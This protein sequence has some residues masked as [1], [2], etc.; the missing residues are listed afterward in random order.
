[1]AQISVIIPVYNIAACLEQCLD[2][3]VGQTFT[4]IEI[5]CVDDGSTDES[6]EILACYADRDDR[7]QILTQKNRGP[8]AARNAGLARATGDYLI[9]L[10]S[11]DWF[12]SE[13]LMQM[14]QRIQ[15]TKADLVI[16]KVVEFDT[17]NGSDRPSSWMLKEK[18]LPK[19]CFRPEEAAEHLFQFTYGWPW[20]KLYRMDFIREKHLSFPELPNSEDVVFVF[21]SLALANRIAI[22]DETLVHHRVN[23][24]NSVSDSREQEPEAPYHAVLLLR[25]GLKE[26]ELYKVFEKSFV[27]WA[28]EFL[29]W[30]AASIKDPALQRDCFQRL[31]RDWLPE[32]G[33]CEK[34]R[35]TSRFAQV[36]Y[37]LVKYLPYPLLAKGLD[38][39]RDCKG[40]W[41]RLWVA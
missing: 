26:K 14:L 8:G 3:V 29:I 37:L 25:D 41:R 40:L 32:M 4:D 38:G 7:F 20:D 31:R 35:F 2:S 5:I 24:V 1:M 16:C 30:N 28:M 12:E 27:T 19:D 36:K 11:D 34:P 9:F 15:K 18:Y 13:F 39:Y 6:P 33:C 23:R 22:L 17:K 21:Q 10:D